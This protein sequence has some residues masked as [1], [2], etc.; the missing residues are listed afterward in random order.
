M[1]YQELGMT[2]C[3]WGY[4]LSG[5]WMGSAIWIGTHLP[6]ASAHPLTSEGWGMLSPLLLPNLVRWTRR[7][8]RAQHSKSGV[9]TLPQMPLHL[10]PPRRI[11]TKNLDASG[12]KQNLLLLPACS[13]QS[14]CF[15]TVGETQKVRLLSCWAEKAATRFIC[16]WKGLSSI[17][18]AIMVRVLQGKGAAAATYRKNQSTNW[19]GSRSKRANGQMQG[20]IYLLLP[21]PHPKQLLWSWLGC[22]KLTEMI[23]EDHFLFPTWCN[24]ET[25]GCPIQIFQDCFK[26]SSGD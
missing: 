12:C 9:V 17:T 2:L 14:V 3:C 26:M 21:Q 20:L 24:V 13:A 6:H 10:F 8:G 1:G 11:D 7:W 23:P 22:Q 4:Q 18:A 25:P 5:G 15:S 19:V 16:L